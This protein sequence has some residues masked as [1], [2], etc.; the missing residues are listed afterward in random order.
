MAYSLKNVAETTMPIGSIVAFYG[1]SP[2]SGWLI[3]DGRSC[4]GTP[5][6]TLTGKT[7]VPDLRGRFIRMIGGNA[8]GMA[9]AQAA[10]YGNHTH[11]MFSSNT[12]GSWITSSNRK[13]YAPNYRAVLRNTTD[14]DDY[15]IAGSGGTANC[16]RTG[17]AGSGTE[18][19][20]INMAFNYII[21]AKYSLRIFSIVDLEE[22]A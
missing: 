16:G 1:T 9:V 13:E 15:V 14:R 3:C 2:P 8:A 4:A 6:A 5:L 19:R 21:K 18:V 20:P 11:Y 12:G 22:V 10:D 7:T 17:P